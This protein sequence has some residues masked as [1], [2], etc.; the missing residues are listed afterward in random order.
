MY[1]THKVY[2]IPEF[3]L[4]HQGQFDRALDQ[5]NLIGNY[6]ECS[7]D[8]EMALTAYARAMA[9]EGIGKSQLAQDSMKKAG[10][11]FEQLD[12]PE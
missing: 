8:L 5:L 11:L 7:D 3:L 4:V 6:Y 9:Y 10:Q 12:I 2:Q 1:Y